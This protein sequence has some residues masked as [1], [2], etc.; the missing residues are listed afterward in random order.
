MCKCAFDCPYT[1]DHIKTLHINDLYLSSLQSY[2]SLSLQSAEAPA[3]FDSL[4][5]LPGLRAFSI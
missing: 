5:G 2:L 4:R 3:G 1:T